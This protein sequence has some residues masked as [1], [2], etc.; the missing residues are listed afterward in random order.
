MLPHFLQLLFWL[1]VS[2]GSTTKLHRMV[3]FYKRV[4]KKSALASNKLCREA[5]MYAHL[6]SPLNFR[7]LL[8]LQSSV[9]SSFLNQSD[10]GLLQPE[11]SA[12]HTTLPHSHLTPP[13]LHSLGYKTLC[14]NVVV[15]PILWFSSATYCFLQAAVHSNT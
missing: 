11:R 10:S 9:P 14:L 2:R 4:I 15:S 5:N 12:G 13:P 8:L 3:G 7:H 1:Q 6:R